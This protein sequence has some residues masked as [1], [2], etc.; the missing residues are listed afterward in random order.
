MKNRLKINTDSV[1]D[2]LYEIGEISRKDIA[3]IGIAVNTA[4]GDTTD[5]M[6]E[7]LRVSFDGI[8]DIPE[9]RKADADNYL[10]FKGKEESEL[11]YYKAGY[12]DEVDKFDYKFFKLSPKEASL[13]DPSQRLFLQTVMHVIEDA[14]YGGE[15]LTGTKTGVYLGYEPSLLYTYGTMIY[16]VEHSAI[17]M[18]VTGNTPA[19]FPSRISYFLDLKGPTVLVDTAC[20][21]SLVAVHMACQGIRSGDCDMAMVGGVKLFLFPVDHP[22]EKIG[23]ESS[24]SKTRS[25]DDSSDGTGYGEGTAVIFIKPLINAIKDNDH[26][27]AV[28]KGSAINQDGNS[29][30]MTAPSAIAQ[31][32]VIEHAWK[33]AGV[34]PETISYIEAHGT[35]TNIGDPIEITGIEKAF[36]KYTDKIQF[37]GLGS[38]KTNVGHL[39]E[40]SG[41]LGLT[42]AALSLKKEELAPLVHFKKPNQKIKFEESPV[43]IVNEMIPWTKENSPRRCGVNAFGF[44]GTNCHV[45]LEEAPVLHKHSGSDETGVKY[46]FTLTAKSIQSFEDY[47]KLYQEYFSSG[48]PTATLKE[49]CYVANTGR[50]H[51]NY[52]LAVAAESYQD[53][54]D[55][56]KGL[57]LSDLK[58]GK[59]ADGIYYGH[60][61][62][63]GNKAP[64]DDTEITD[65]KKQEL[66]SLLSEKMTLFLSSGKKDRSLL[67]EICETYIQGADTDWEAVYSDSRV[68]KVKLPVYPFEK[69]RCWINVPDVRPQYDD[70]GLFYN[71]VWVKEEASAIQSELSQ[72]AV[73]YLK[74]GKA[75]STLQEDFT[76]GLKNKYH[77]LVVVEI[78]SEYEKHS[79]H[80][81]TIRNLEEDYLTLLLDIKAAGLSAVIHAL[82]LENSAPAVTMQD[83]QGGLN[84]GLY[85]LVYFNRALHKA[86]IRNDFNF[87]FLSYA[88][89]E[90]TGQEKTILPEHAALFGLAK[91]FDRENANINSKCVDVDETI[92]ADIL[93]RELNG[94]FKASQV[95]YR[96]GD[97]YVEEF[98]EV[99]VVKE[100]KDEPVRFKEDGVYIITGGTGGIGLETA[101]YIAGKAKVHLAFVNRSKMPERPEWQGI[102]NTGTDK[103]LC[104]KIN[105]ILNIEKTGSHVH[106]YSADISNYEAMEKVYQNLKLKLK[107]ING[108]IHAAGL[109]TD[110][111]FIGIKNAEAFDR[112]VMPKIQ[113]TWILEKLTRDDNLDFFVL[114]S[115]VATFFGGPGQGDY[116]AGNAY[117]D[118]FT[119]HMLKNGRKAVCINWVQW[120]ETGMAVATKANVNTIF[121][122]LSNKQ[123]IDALDKMINSNVQRALVGEINYGN[124]M[125]LLL[126]RVSMRLSAR[127]QANLE[128]Q[129][130]VSG[131]KNKNKKQTEVGEVVLKGKDNQPVTE[132]EKKVAQVWGEVLGYQELKADDNFYEL[133]GD[134]I[135]AIRICNKI[136]IMIDQNVSIAEALNHHTITDLARYLDETYSIKSENIYATL[137]PVEK[138]EYYPL[139]SAQKRLYVMNQLSPMNI[140]YN[141][142]DI[143]ILKTGFELKKFEKTINSI[144]QRHEALRTSF[145]FVNNEAVQII[146]D[147]IQIQIKWLGS[148]NGDNQEINTDKILKEFMRPFA[149]DKAPLMRFG[150]VKLTG[151]E[152]MIICDKHHIIWDAMSKIIFTREFLRIYNGEDLGA[153]SALQYK[154]YAVWQQSI[155]NSALLKKQEEYWMG[156]F[157]GNIP[158]LELPTDYPRPNHEIQKGDRFYFNVDG[159]AREAL[160]K[161]A[162]DHQTTLYSVLLSAYY[163]LLSKYS[164]QED[165]VVGVPVLGRG[166]RDLEN[167]IGIFVN[168]I[169]VRNYPT[170]NK[171]YGDF[172]KEVH[173]NAFNAFDNQEMQFEMLVE[174]LG[175][176][177]EMNR[178]PIFNVAFVL[179]NVQGIKSDNFVEYDFANKSSK[180]DLTL[181]ATETDDRIKLNIEYSTDLFKE[182]TIRRM[183]QD[184]LKIFTS[185]IEDQSV[186]I[187]SISLGNNFTKVEKTIKEEVVF[188]F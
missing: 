55:K 78:G 116:T 123:G 46:V 74:P 169:P 184:Y 150:V 151:E 143:Y 104:E 139:S 130:Q 50:G 7:N 101:K 97:R 60:H 118:S 87:Y 125:L 79:A 52:R 181:E 51:Y 32:E 133:G 21:S 152:H 30:S 160:K 172:L 77:N 10:R 110:G 38:I 117:L 166:H 155:S 24:N 115:S 81:Y 57:S 147:N 75:L 108:V 137:K 56:V 72:G 26:I 49:I 176:S 132:M 161:I 28:I 100:K 40:A 102:L 1:N 80:H 103:A 19:V 182:K 167:I 171:R 144:I 54:S 36:R 31:A 70:T 92:S 138:R 128:K 122:A 63:I 136:N 124:E 157:K 95:A 6:W 175:I 5:K 113:G 33:Q 114:Y 126:E 44:S 129:K 180:F 41:I 18:S 165:L 89:S 141:L 43:Y 135:L 88:V 179:Q 68:N 174:K 67:N 53:L 149:L 145:S 4:M 12:L 91:I 59:L 86:A 146:H 178:N 170:G 29:A 65:A 153:P 71:A 98:R 47:L 159:D 3:I 85:S 111:V 106:C 39:F 2:D 94:D 62:T 42:K 20:S 73:L 83:L 131:P 158:E 119:S 140:N 127:I 25:F 17:Q 134:S 177:R 183:S 186:S 187:S 69:T 93:L 35:G 27:Y 11:K 148:L 23:I 154:D 37:C 84:K 90:V 121:K 185:I 109:P 13:M 8:R 188:D 45:I 142:P 61:K 14:G 173:I 82:T 107:R 9:S 112:I 48:K 162:L 76:T 156:L 164:G 120:L 15:K 66:N 34:D 99:D 16:D 64:A 58:N 105:A 163:I 96:S 168:T 22:E